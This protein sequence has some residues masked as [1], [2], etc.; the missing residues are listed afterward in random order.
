VQLGLGLRKYRTMRW[1]K[2]TISLDIAFYGLG[3][4]SSTI[5]QTIGF[6]SVTAGTPQHQIQ[7]SLRNVSI[8]NIILAVGGLV[9][10]P[11]SSSYTDVQIPGYWLTFAFIDFWGRKPIQLMGF[12]ILVSELPLYSHSH[13]LTLQTIIFICMGFGYEKMQS[14]HAGKS[15]FVVCSHHV[16]RIL[17]TFQFLYCMANLFQ[18][19]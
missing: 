8:G 13:S 17:L 6:G 12:I 2:L 3:L 15:A 14:T 1:N 10:C 4:N 7:Q 16:H 9:G 19:E 5:L 11:A 18:S